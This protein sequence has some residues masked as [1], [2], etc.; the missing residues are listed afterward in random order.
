MNGLMHLVQYTG[1][2]WCFD[3][4]NEME[5]MY[6]FSRVGFKIQERLVFLL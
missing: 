2:Y 4:P 3:T 1:W 5:Q 6:I